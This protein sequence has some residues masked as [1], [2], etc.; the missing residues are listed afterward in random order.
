MALLDTYDQRIMHLDSRL[1]GS[2]MPLLPV[3]GELV[4]EI[5][6][7]HLAPGQYRIELWLQTS[8]VVQD[9]INHAALVEVAEG[10]FFGT[11]RALTRGFQVALMD[12]HWSI[13]EPDRKPRP[14]AQTPVSD[15]QLTTRVR[16]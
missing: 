1:S 16:T 3:G 13:R 2:E 7:V 12:F 10:N 14:A 4:C 15:P 8:G 11:G 9:H 6:R 5:P